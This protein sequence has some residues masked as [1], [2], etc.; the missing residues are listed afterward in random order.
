M[1]LVAYFTPHEA[2]AVPDP[3]KPSA[4]LL[5]ALP[6][7]DDGRYLPTHVE[8]A[9]VFI[10]ENGLSAAVTL[11]VQLDKADSK[12]QRLWVAAV[13]YNARGEVVGVRR[14]ENSSASPLE[15]G[16]A[17]EVRLSIYS[18]SGEIARVELFSEA[19]P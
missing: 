17:L 7:P 18:V 1:P 6:N 14:W 16:K 13:A 19:R 10:A 3:L 2:E 12:A 8:G 11:K 9:N 5:S 15:S 4:R